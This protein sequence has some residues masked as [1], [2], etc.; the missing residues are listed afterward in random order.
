MSELPKIVPEKITLQSVKVLSGSINSS[1]AVDPDRIIGYNTHFDFAQ[2]L[3]VENNAVRVIIGV[4]LVARDVDNNKLDVNG[5]YKTEFI[6][7]VENLKDFVIENEKQK[8]HQIIVIN[9]LLSGTLAGIAYSTLRGI[10]LSRTQGTALEGVILPVIDPV[11][12]I[13][14]EFN[15]KK[16]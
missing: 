5:E 16:S 11:K 15:E 12:L 1:E 10:V 3:N 14:G 4:R 8:S 7:K 6:F 9:S 13:N 2:G